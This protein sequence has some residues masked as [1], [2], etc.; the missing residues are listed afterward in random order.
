MIPVKKRRSWMGSV[1]TQMIQTQAK[2]VKVKAKKMTKKTSKAARLKR[3]SR[4][5]GRL[6][7]MWWLRMVRRIMMNPTYLPSPRKAWMMNK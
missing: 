3:M 6:W 2:I 5:C 1:Q 4:T 7:A